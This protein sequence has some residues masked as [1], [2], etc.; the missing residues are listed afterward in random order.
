MT[1]NKKKT[2]R[3]EDVTDNDAVKPVKKLKVKEAKDKL[4]EEAL[5]EDI[6][7]EDLSESDEDSNE[8]LKEVQVE[9]SSVADTAQDEE[10]G[11]AEK[12]IAARKI[13]SATG[14]LIPEEIGR[15]HV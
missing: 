11:E 6:M 9:K 2:P 8:D 3:K 10:N 14:D 4:I 12:V 15:A 7:P 1:D 5:E 13:K